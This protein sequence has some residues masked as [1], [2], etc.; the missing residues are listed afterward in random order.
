MKTIARA[1]DAAPPAPAAST[2]S[3]IERQRRFHSGEFEIYADRKAK[4]FVSMCSGISDRGGRIQYILSIAE[5]RDLA[6]ELLLAAEFASRPLLGDS[7]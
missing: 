5:A 1:L 6:D 2:P 7:K 4:P 3:A